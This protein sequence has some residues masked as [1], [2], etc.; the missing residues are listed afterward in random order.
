MRSILAIAVLTLCLPVF[1][2]CGIGSAVRARHDG[3]QLT[4]DEKHR[5]YSAALAASES[6]LDTDLFKHVCRKIGIFDAG[7][8]PNDAYLAFVAEHINWSM[9]PEIDEF[10]REINTKEKAVEYVRRH[11]PQ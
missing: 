11:L 6:P 5:L 7:G 4:E 1:T 2:S 10:K 9:K 8:K 3:L